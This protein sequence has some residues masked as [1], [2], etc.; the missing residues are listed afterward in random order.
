MCVVG[1]EKGVELAAFTPAE[2][3]RWV[4]LHTHVWTQPREQLEGFLSS[5]PKQLFH[6]GTLQVEKK[7]KMP[8][9]PPSFL[10]HRV[11]PCLC[12]QTAP[13]DVTV[14][15]VIWCQGL[16]IP[17]AVFPDHFRSSLEASAD[18]S[19]NRMVS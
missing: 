15:L 17:E 9:F 16:P 11:R 8:Q 6:I 1:E 13:K 12:H 19:L 3:G 10:P 7:Q 2:S 14:M 18:V 4:A 5:C